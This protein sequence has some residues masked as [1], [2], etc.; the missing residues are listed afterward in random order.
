MGETRLVEI[1]NKAKIQAWF[2]DRG[3]ISSLVLLLPIS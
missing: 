3:T 2:W 1:A